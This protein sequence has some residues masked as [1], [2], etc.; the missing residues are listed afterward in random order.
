M[1]VVSF[2]I[3]IFI[4]TVLLTLPISAKSGRFT[5]PVDALFT[6]TSATCVTGLSVYDTFMHWSYFGQG[7]L[8]VLI[9]C[10]GL[11]LAA[12]ATGLTLLVRRRIGIRHLVLARESAG[13][14]NLDVISLL[15]IVVAFTFAVEALGALL[16]MARFVPLYGGL[17]AWASVFVS[18]SAFCNAGFD[19]L[20]FIPGN[21]SLSA[22]N[23]DPLVTLTISALI[24]IGGLGFVVWR[25]LVHCRFRFS[26]LQLHTRLVLTVTGILLGGGFGALLLAAKKADRKT[27]FAFGPFLCI[28]IAAAMFFGERLADWY[29]GLL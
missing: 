17:G 24:V 26:K 4:G 22:F 14:S 29:I 19:I 23:G 8:L 2:V 11:G 18:V 5:N 12:F 7:V 27:R 15:R 10:G 20:S 3:L 16:L 28:G 6:A 13:G 25:D 1:F 9:Q 21:S